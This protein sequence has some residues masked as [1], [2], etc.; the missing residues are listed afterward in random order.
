MITGEIVGLEEL[1]KK[2]DLI[3]KSAEKT[4]TQ[5]AEEGKKHMKSV[6]P[7]QTGALINA[8]VSEGRPNV[9][10]IRSMQPNRVNF[11]GRLVP[12]HVIMHLTNGHMG[13][14]VRIKSGNPRYAIETFNW[15]KE[16]FATKVSE[17]IS[18]S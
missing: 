3:I 12:Y 17:N 6:A 18:R 5:I 9:A 2:F 14:G 7:R 4:P 13:R 15:L 10:Y 16:R 11:Q 8:I 1:K